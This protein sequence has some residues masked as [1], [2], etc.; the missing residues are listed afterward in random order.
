MEGKNT[1]FRVRA[2]IRFLNLNII[3]LLFFYLF[4]APPQEG[5]TYAWNI[6]SRPWLR[7]ASHRPQPIP[8]GQYELDHPRQNKE[9]NSW[10]KS[11]RA[12][13]QIYSTPVGVDER[14]ILNQSTFSSHNSSA[15]VSSN[16]RKR[17]FSRQDR[18]KFY[19]FI[20]KKNLL[21]Y[22]KNS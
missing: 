17:L 11:N 15:N 16:T 3:M 20:K 21:N 14:E 1:I 4:I 19:S 18:S 13:S 9:K 6:F 5:F 22:S 12:N 7:T 10:N 2:T 8:W